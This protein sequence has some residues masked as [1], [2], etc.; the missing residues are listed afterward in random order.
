MN[1]QNKLIVVSLVFLAIGFVIGI[2]VGVTLFFS[3]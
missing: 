2:G 1:R 3:K